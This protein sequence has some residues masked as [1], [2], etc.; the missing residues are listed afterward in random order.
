MS[1]TRQSTHR[2]VGRPLDLRAK[3]LA[4]TAGGRAPAWLRYKL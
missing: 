2:L 4:Q 3:E 1:C